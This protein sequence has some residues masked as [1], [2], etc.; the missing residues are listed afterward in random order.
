MKVKPAPLQENLITSEPPL[1]T[2][3]YEDS[4]PLLW[5]VE[6]HVGPYDATL[7]LGNGQAACDG[8]LLAG[9]GITSALNVAVN[10]PLAPLILPDGMLLRRSHVGL[11]DG[12]GNTAPHLL[13]AMLALAGLLTQA[14]PG[15]AGYPAHRPGNILV[16]CRGGRSRGVAVLAL[17]LHLALTDRYPTL[18][19]ALDHLRGVRGLDSTEPCGPLWQLMIQCLNSNLSTWLKGLLHG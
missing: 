14:S 9:R 2:K 7:F 5:L 10:L 17:F 19:D 15:K 11:I 8:E 4:R 3:Q 13:A 6:Q 12:R 16:H 1:S 18:K